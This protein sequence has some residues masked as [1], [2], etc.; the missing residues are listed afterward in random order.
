MN[1]DDEA[2][3]KYKLGKLPARPDAVQMK[4]GSFIKADRL[5]VPPLRIGHELIGHDW[6]VLGNTK[7]S[8]CVFAGAAHE[9]MVWSHMGSA[10]PGADFTEINV[11]SDYAAATGWDGTEKTDNGADMSDA[12]SYRR[13]IGM[14]DNNNVRHKV[15]AYLALRPGDADDLALAVWLTGAVGI[16]INTPKNAMSKFDLH[17]PWDD[18]ASPYTVGG[19]YICVIGRN[20]KG[21]WLVV[22]WG[23]VQGMSQSFYQK[24]C[25]E[26]L[27]YITP[28]VIRKNT[29]LSP[30]GFALAEIRKEVAQLKGAHEHG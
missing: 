17:Q 8:D 11:L 3:T 5:P 21:L 29:G 12:A 30:E 7:H 16:G 23:R 22:S 2:L 13:R 27:V 20:T 6:R 15:E 4:F 14:I 28:E 18:T 25:D 9:H 24:F 26:A 19:H 1:I 10:G